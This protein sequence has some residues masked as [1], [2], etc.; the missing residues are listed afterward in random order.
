MLQECKKSHRHNDVEDKEEESRYVQC[1]SM[2]AYIY[3]WMQAKTRERS[4]IIVAF[5]GN[6][7]MHYK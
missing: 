5:L 3:I 7:E 1:V 4:I 2:T 6:I